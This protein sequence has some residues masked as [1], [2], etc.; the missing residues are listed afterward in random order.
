MTDPTDRPETFLDH[1]R[2]AAA[3]VLE[4]FPERLKPEMYA[5]SFR[6]WRVD[7]DDRHPYVA[8]GYNTESQY[9][10][11][12]YPG[13]EGEVRWNYAYWLL[14]GFEMLGNIPED[15]VGSRVYVEEVKQLGVWYDGEFDLDRVLDD[16]DLSARTDLLR[17]HFLRRRHRPRPPP[18]RRRRDREDL[19]PPAARRGLRHGVPRLGG[20]RDGVRQSAGAGRGVHGVAAG[21]R[22]DLIAGPVLPVGRRQM[23]RQPR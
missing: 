21:G 2:A 6:I 11:E 8:I 22:G 20:A 3:G 14:D 5:L 23:P 7:A 10:R 9:E 19:R 1:L 13:G 17:L 12:K 4:R 16:D 18:P 15:P